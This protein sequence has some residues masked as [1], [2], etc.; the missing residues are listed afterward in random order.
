MMMPM[1][2]DPELPEPSRRTRWSASPYELSALR[3]HLQ[4]ELGEERVYV[5]EAGLG[6]SG[7]QLVVEVRVRS[8]LEEDD[9]ELVQEMTAV[10]EAWLRER[11]RPG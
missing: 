11:V 10:A 1:L 8:P 7:D 9:E 4:R 2:L 3:D 6:A 5:E